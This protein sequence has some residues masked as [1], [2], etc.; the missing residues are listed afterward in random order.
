MKAH[1][2]LTGMLF[3]TLASAAL[4]TE[5]GEFRA[6]AHKT[7]ISQ[8]DRLADVEA[9]IDFGRE[10]AVRIL[11]RHPLV[12]DDALARYVS[13]VGQAVAL[14]SNRPELRFH[15]G[16][17][18]S[19]QVNA[20]AAPGGYIFVT[21][22]ALAL[23]RDEAELAAVLAHEIAHVTE[24]HIVNALHISASDDSAIA[25]ASRLLGGVGD[26][27]RVAFLQSVDK[28]LAILFEAGLAQADELEADRVGTGL[29]AVAGY[30][31][32]ALRRYLDRVRRQAGAAQLAVI[33]HTHP[34][35]AERLGAL[36]H[37]LQQQGLA[38]HAGPTV[39]ARFH[40]Y[41]SHD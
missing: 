24:R 3:L 39:R 29:L 17:V 14:H 5:P 35:F 37:E 19:D 40:H 8:S 18:A 36:D 7:A 2:L 33:T 4:A 34:P 6:R 23:M 27:T 25:G 12:A 13:L 26:P 22:A 11:G 10:V 28:A 41:V 1:H 16:V 9:E 30:D 31:A 15:F 32:T 38:G 21:T 20:Y